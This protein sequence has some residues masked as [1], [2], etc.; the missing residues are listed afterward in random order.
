[1]KICNCC[2]RKF[3][4]ERLKFCFTCINAEQIIE[5]GQDLDGRRSPN[6]KGSASMDRVKFLILKGWKPPKEKR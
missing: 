3:D 1:M 6:T 2:A 4:G 5:T